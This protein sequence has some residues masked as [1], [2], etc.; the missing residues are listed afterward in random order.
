MVQDRGDPVDAATATTILTMPET[1][2]PGHSE[3][4]PR[5]CTRTR[6]EAH[7]SQQK[8]RVE[9]LSPCRSEKL[10]GWLDEDEADLLPAPL[11]KFGVSGRPRG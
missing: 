1:N 11:E 7:S 6:S 8:G 10:H 2:D 9:T 4:D 5:T 3:D